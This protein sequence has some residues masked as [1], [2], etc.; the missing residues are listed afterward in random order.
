MTLFFDSFDCLI[1]NFMLLK[2]LPLYSSME[3][4]KQKDIFEIQRKDTNNSACIYQKIILA[5]NIAETF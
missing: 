1:E 4:N 2:C 3:I 5:T